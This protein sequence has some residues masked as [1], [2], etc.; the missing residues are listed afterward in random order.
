MSKVV[1][2][3]VGFTFVEASLKHL[4]VD[5]I[6]YITTGGIVNDREQLCCILSDA[7]AVVIG[8]EKIDRTVLDA[9]KDLKTIVRFGT[10]TEN[11]DVDYAS[12]KGIK[13][14]SIKSKH[15]V[16]GVARLCTTFLLN[17]SFNLQKHYR[18]ASVQTWARY[19]NLTPANTKVGLVGAGAIAMEFLKMGQ[20]LGFD[21]SYHSRSPKKAFSD[22]SIKFYDNISDLVENSDVIS[23]HVPF[24]HTTSNLLSAELLD[25]CA[26]K[27]VIN[28]SRAG[29]IDQIKLNELLISEPT[30]Y[31]FTDVLNSEP[32][33][34]ED[35]QLIG[36]ENVLSSAHVGGYSHDALLDVAT[37]ALEILR[38]EL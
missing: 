28:T 2:T 38:T 30:F 19:V 17:Y 27:L 13:V 12:E 20:Q 29:V 8:S 21:F 18:D 35:F 25:M 15:T 22:R 10:S 37:Q 1:I 4:Y 31:Y 14:F 7:C 33:C 11:I 26:G 9:A 34:D 16:T 3:P 36:R 23:L 24:N 5:G 6:E 32:P